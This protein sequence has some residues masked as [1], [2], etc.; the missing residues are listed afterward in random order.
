MSSRVIASYR[1]LWLVAPE[2]KLVF[3]RGRLTET[4]VA[5]DRVLLEN[6]TYP[7]AIEA[8][9]RTGARLV[10]L[11]VGAEGWDVDARTGRAPEPGAVDLQA[12]DGSVVRSATQVRAALGAAAP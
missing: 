8:V 6:P 1:G 11:P 10:A 12:A 7:N 4:P 3:A 5:G 2:N 9:R